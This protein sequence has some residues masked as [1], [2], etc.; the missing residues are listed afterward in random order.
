MVVTE[1]YQ[2]PVG[3]EVEYRAGG[4]HITGEVVRE[5]Y[6]DELGA[7]VMDVKY[8][9]GNLAGMVF[10]EIAEIWDAA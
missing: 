9:N 8:T 6:T 7:T 2:F 5:P 3:A 10:D 1:K 4:R